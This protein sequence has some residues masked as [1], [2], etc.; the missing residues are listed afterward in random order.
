M[1]KSRKKRFKICEVKLSLKFFSQNWYEIF[2]NFVK[3]RIFLQ[4]FKIHFREI[5]TLFY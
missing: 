4:K 5:L 2:L 3:N 1:S